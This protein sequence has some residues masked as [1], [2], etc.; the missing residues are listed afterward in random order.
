MLQ[1]A[2]REHR[3][4]YFISEGDNGRPE[5]RTSP[6]DE[7]LWMDSQIAPQPDS[8]TMFTGLSMTQCAIFERL[9]H[10]KLEGRPIKVHRRHIC[11]SDEES[12]FD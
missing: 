3:R 4:A 5:G 6:E 10:S 11:C 7:G 9:P 2:S 8:R 12:C 1:M